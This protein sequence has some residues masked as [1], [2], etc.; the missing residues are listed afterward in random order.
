MFLIYGKDLFEGD[1]MRFVVALC[2]FFGVVAPAAAIDFTSWKYPEFALPD[3]PTHVD[4][5]QLDMPEAASPVKAMIHH[6][7]TEVLVI[8]TLITIFVSALL[9]YVMLRFRASKNP[10][11][12]KTT[13]HTLLE[14]VWTAVPI[15]ILIVIAVPSL[16]LLYFMDKSPDQTAARDALKKGEDVKVYDEMTLKVVGY[17]WYWGY[18]YPDHGGFGF[19]SYMLEDAKLTKE[20][21]YRLL[22]V[23]NR[24]VLPV[25]T[26]V[27]IQITA[28]D[29][30]HSFAMPALGF[31]T[32][33]VPGR[34][35][36]TWVRIE[37]PGVYYGQCS[38]LCGVRHGFMPIVIEA[39]SKADFAKWVEGAK[40][41][42]AAV[43]TPQIA[44]K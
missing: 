22:E 39:V 1:S 32:D 13:H 23:D 7:H 10:V 3:R 18:Q 28:A 33:A 40:K 6:F 37:K 44:A 31:K 43:S 19:E 9:V 11:A 24:I 5:W 29:V 21:P 41:Q 42:F 27:R 14:V 17:Q 25:D 4:Q 15:L 36:E 2:L 35:N 8:I 26:N 30:I 16:K 20:R 38:E 12:S 34:L